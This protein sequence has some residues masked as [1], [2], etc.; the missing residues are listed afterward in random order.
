MALC[1]FIRQGDMPI[2]IALQGEWGSGKSSFMKMMEQCL[3]SETLSDEE[4]FDSI[5]INTWELFWETDHDVAVK[6]LLLNLVM[7]LE[8]NFEKKKRGAKAEERREIMKEYLKNISGFALESFNMKNEYSDKILD[9][10]FSEKGTTK[11]VH[12]VVTK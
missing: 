1:Q 6:K 2:T 11:S 4:R 8:E 12:A 5:W 9:R 10:V 3:C 7:Q